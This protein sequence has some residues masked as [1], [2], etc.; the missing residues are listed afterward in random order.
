M[1]DIYEKNHISACSWIIKNKCQNI[2]TKRIFN[3]FARCW[4]SKEY[5]FGKKSVVIYCGPPIYQ[6]FY[7]KKSRYT[8]WLLKQK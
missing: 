4:D 7:F 2:V 8:L 1:N 6:K 3:P 5:L